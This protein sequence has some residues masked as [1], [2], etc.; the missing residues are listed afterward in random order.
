MTDHAFKPERG[1]LYVVGT[2]IGNLSDLSFRAA[3][4]LKQVNWVAAEDTRNS[5]KLLSSIGAETPLISCHEHSS[6]AKITALVNRLKAGESGA[7]VSDAGTPAVSDP[8]AALVRAVRD[9]GLSVQPIPGASA[10]TALLS[11]AGFA[12]ATVSFH[13]FFPRASGE[14][15]EFL[16]R[17]ARFG[18]AH[19]F[20]EAPGRL[21]D[22]LGLIAEFFPDAEL[23][24]G[25]ELTKKFEEIRAG[26]AHEVAA[27]FRGRAVKGECALALALPEA[28]AAPAVARDEAL[29][30]L[31]D[32][33]ALGASQKIL[34]AV[35]KR[36]G[37]S[38]KEAYALGLADPSAE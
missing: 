3:E 31:T 7:Y 29:A 38:R 9:S 17:L 16:Q 1:V 2:P 21:T 11:V 25:R 26:R 14:R 18:G 4:V 28:E 13:G 34:V 10:L 20:F 24:V 23:V 5:R 35:G 30:L 32:L 33:R 15:R 19:V 12:A 8:G 27:Q 37:L 22:C 36:L 6:E